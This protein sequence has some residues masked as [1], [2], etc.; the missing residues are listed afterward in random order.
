MNYCIKWFDDNNWWCF[1][2][3]FFLVLIYIKHQTALNNLYPPPSSKSINKTMSVCHERTFFKRCLHTCTNNAVFSKYVLVWYPLNVNSK[4]TRNQITN[5]NK[6]VYTFFYCSQIWC[7]SSLNWSS[8]GHFC[9]KWSFL[10]WRLRLCVIFW[11]IQTLRGWILLPYFT[12]AKSEYAVWI[13]SLMNSI[14]PMRWTKWIS[15]VL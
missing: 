2:D 9:A 7:L 10:V 5:I 1:N 8:W 4:N 12:M 11:L 3:F 6:K 13:L 14:V 15:N